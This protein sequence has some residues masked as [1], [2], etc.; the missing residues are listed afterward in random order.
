MKESSDGFCRSTQA[1]K[2]RRLHKRHTESLSERMNG[3]VDD[4]DFGD[5]YDSCMHNFPLSSSFLNSDFPHPTSG[6]LFGGTRLVLGNHLLPDRLTGRKRK[7]RPGEA[8]SGSDVLQDRLRFAGQI[9]TDPAAMPDRPEG[10]G[11][12][13]SDGRERRRLTRGGVRAVWR[14]NSFRTTSATAGRIVP[15]PECAH[16]PPPASASDT[17]IGCEVRPSCV[18]Y[19][20]QLSHPCHIS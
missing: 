14:R 16:T 9:R 7:D 13:G 5:D 20:R 18:R 3:I 8:R 17:A 11:Q 19:D 6:N 15:P 10:R 2:N 12:A 4:Y 1:K